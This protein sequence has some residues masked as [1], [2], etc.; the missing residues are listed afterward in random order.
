MSWSHLKILLG[1]LKAVF[2]SGPILRR[3][4]RLKFLKEFTRRRGRKWSVSIWMSSSLSWLMLLVIFICSNHSVSHFLF[5]CLTYLVEI[6][7]QLNSPNYP[8]FHLIYWSRSNVCS[9]NKF[10]FQI[11]QSKTMG[12]PLYWVKQLE[13]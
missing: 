7:V 10:V 13:L 6:F 5:V 8:R 1:Y 3:R 9:L 4:I 11:W 12:R 2:G